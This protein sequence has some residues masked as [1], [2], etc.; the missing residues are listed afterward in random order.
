LLGQIRP[1]VKLR[2][3]ILIERNTPLALALHGDE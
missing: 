1:A 2:W 3:G